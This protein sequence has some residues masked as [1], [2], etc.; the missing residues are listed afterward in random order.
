MKNQLSF[1]T[2]QLIIFVNILFD[3]HFIKS[4]YY[5]NYIL[6]KFHIKR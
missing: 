5:V 6:W 3:L 4:Y 1:L 2:Y